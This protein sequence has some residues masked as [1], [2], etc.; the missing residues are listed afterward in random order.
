MLYDREC[1]ICN[2]VEEYGYNE[3]TLIKCKNCNVFFHKICYGVSGNHISTQGI[4]ILCDPCQYDLQTKGKHLNK[5]GPGKDLKCLICFNTGILKRVLV[6]MKFDLFQGSNSIQGTQSRAIWIH[7]ECAIYSKDYISIGNWRNMSN[8][9]VLKPLVYLND[10]SCSF[11]LGNM[12]LL[13][14]CA[15]PACQEFLHAHCLL[16]S[17]SFKRRNFKIEKG[18]FPIICCSKHLCDG[19]QILLDQNKESRKFIIKSLKDEINSFERS[20]DLDGYIIRVFESH[21]ELFAL[22]EFL[23]PNKSLKR[24]TLLGIIVLCD[25]WTLRTTAFLSLFNRPFLIGGRNGLTLTTYQNI[26]N[27]IELSRYIPVNQKYRDTLVSLRDQVSNFFC[28][29]EDIRSKIKDNI[30]HYIKEIRNLVNLEIISEWENKYS[31]YLRIFKVRGKENRLDFEILENILRDLP[32]IKDNVSHWE[33]CR[34]SRLY[35]EISRIKL[36]IQRLSL[37]LKRCLCSRTINIDKLRSLVQIIEC[38]IP[39]NSPLNKRGCKKILKSLVFLE[40]GL[41]MTLER[42]VL[43]KFGDKVSIRFKNE[44]I[45]NNFEEFVNF[46]NSFRNKKTLMDLISEIDDFEFE[47]INHETCN[48]SLLKMEVSKENCNSLKLL[49]GDENISEIPNKY[50]RVLCSRR[51]TSILKR[52]IKLKIWERRVEK[53]FLTVKKIQESCFHRNRRKKPRRDLTLKEIYCMF[54]Q[55]FVQGEMGTRNLQ[56]EFSYLRTEADGDK[57]NFFGSEAFGMYTYISDEIRKVREIE[58][59]YSNRDFEFNFNGIFLLMDFILDFKYPILPEKSSLKLV[60]GKLEKYLAIESFLENSLQIPQMSLRE[61]FILNKYLSLFD[62]YKGN[63]LYKTKFFLDFEILMN[64]VLDK[65]MK[66]FNYFLG[67]FLIIS[68]SDSLSISPLGASSD[69]KEVL[70]ILDYLIRDGKFTRSLNNGFMDYFLNKTSVT[71]NNCNETKKIIR[72]K[73]MILLSNYRDNLIKYISE[74][75]LFREIPISMDLSYS[76]NPIEIPIKWKLK[77]IQR[78]FVVN[79]I[80]RFSNEIEESRDIEE[81]IEEVFKAL[82]FELLVVIWRNLRLLNSREDISRLLAS[83]EIAEENVED[84]IFENDPWYDLVVSFLTNRITENLGL[85]I[86]EGEMSFGPI[87]NYMDDLKYLLEGNTISEKLLLEKIASEIDEVKEIDKSIEEVIQN[88]N[89]KNFEY[90]ERIIKL[91]MNEHFYTL[92]QQG[93]KE[94]NNFF[95]RDMKDTQDFSF[96]VLHQPISYDEEIFDGSLNQDFPLKYSNSIFDPVP[97]NLL[98]QEKS[99]SILRSG[100]YTGFQNSF[101]EGVIKDFEGSSHRNIRTLLQEYLI[102]LQEERNKILFVLARSKKTKFLWF[103]DAKFPLEFGSF[104]DELHKRNKRIGS[105]IDLLNRVVNEM[106]HLEISFLVNLI[107]LHNQDFK[108]SKNDLKEWFDESYLKSITPFNLFRSLVGIGDLV[109]PILVYKL[110]DEVSSRYLERISSWTQ[111]YLEIVEIGRGYQISHD[112]YEILLLY[113]QN[114]HLKRIFQNNFDSVRDPCS[115][116]NVISE[117][118]EE[119]FG[120]RSSRIREEYQILRSFLGDLIGLLKSHINAVFKDIAVNGLYDSKSSSKFLVYLPQDL[121]QILRTRDSRVSGSP[122]SIF[123]DEISVVYFSKNISLL[124]LKVNMTYK[125]EIYYLSPEFLVTLVNEIQFNA[126]IL[127]SFFFS[128]SRRHFE[129]LYALSPVKEH[130]YYYFEGG[131]HKLPDLDMVNTNISNFESRIKSQI[132]S[133]SNSV[134]EKGI[135]SVSLDSFKIHETLEN[136]NSRFIP[137]SDIL[138]LV[139][140]IFYFRIFL[141]NLENPSKR[142]NPQLLDFDLALKVVVMQYSLEKVIPEISFLRDPTRMRNEMF[143]PTEFHTVTQ[144]LASLS[145]FFKTKDSIFLDFNNKPNIH[146]FLFERENMLME[147]FQVWECISNFYF[148]KEN[149]EREDNLSDF[150]LNSIIWVP[151]YENFMTFVDIIEVIF[152]HIREIRFFVLDS[153]NVEKISNLEKRLEMKKNSLQDHGTNSLELIKNFDLYEIENTTVEARSTPFDILEKSIS[154]PKITQRALHE[155]LSKNLF[156]IIPNYKL[157]HQTLNILPFKGFEILLNIFKNSVTVDKQLSRH[158]ILIQNLETENLD[159]KDHEKILSHDIKYLAEILDLR[160]LINVARVS[161]DTL[162]KGYSQFFKGIFRYYLIY[163]TNNRWVSISESQ[164]EEEN[165]G[166]LVFVPIIDYSI[167]KHLYE[168]FLLWNP[169][170]Y[171]EKNPGT[172]RS[173]EF[174][175]LESLI[176]MGCYLIE[177][178]S[179]SDQPNKNEDYL[180][181]QCLLRY[182]YFSE[183]NSMEKLEFSSYMGILDIGKYLTEYM[184]LLDMEFIIKNDLSKKDLEDSH[185]LETCEIGSSNVFSKVDCKLVHHFSRKNK[186]RISLTGIKDPEYGLVSNIHFLKENQQKIRFGWTPGRISYSLKPINSIYFLRNYVKQYLKF[187]FKVFYNRD[188]PEYIKNKDHSIYLGAFGADEQLTIENLFYILTNYLKNMVDYTLKLLV[189]SVKIKSRQNHFLYSNLSKYPRDLERLRKQWIIKN[190]WVSNLNK[191]E[192]IG[193][194]EIKQKLDKKEFKKEINDMGSIQKLNQS[195]RDRDRME[196]K[197]NETDE[198]SEE[199]TLKT[200]KRGISKE[201]NFGLKRKEA[202]KHSTDK[203]RE[204]IGEPKETDSLDTEFNSKKNERLKNHQGNISDLRFTWLGWL[205]FEEEEIKGQRELLDIGLY[206]I[207]NQFIRNDEILDGLNKGLEFRYNGMRHSMEKVEKIYD[208]LVVLVSSNW[209]EWLRS[210]KSKIFNKLFHFQYSREEYEIFEFEMKEDGEKTEDK[211]DSGGIRLLIFPCNLN[212]DNLSRIF[213]RREKSRFPI[214]KN[215]LLGMIVSKKVLDESLEEVSGEQNEGD[216]ASVFG[217]LLPN[218]EQLYKVAHYCHNKSLK[219]SSKM[220]FLISNIGM[221]SSAGTLLSSLLSVNNNSLSGT[222]SQNNGNSNICTLKDLADSI[223]RKISQGS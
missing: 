113:N 30:L 27:W 71:I 188:D 62:T 49:S 183:K 105:R 118:D 172:F 194:K 199:V 45:D 56:V 140:N 191:K 55:K 152:L 84:V 214:S 3:L 81:L 78:Y 123:I 161:S 68:E 186:I 88:M 80:S 206:Q 181:K 207:N 54:F 16:K 98:F 176:Y 204:I 47:N 135:F 89:G 18:R 96:P 134:G 217:S 58:G 91:V 147:D 142:G 40:N 168:E 32:L 166:N 116:E 46:F 23:L 185:A 36:R 7:I 75:D 26:I 25:I 190:K 100:G 90:K 162:L 200:D 10:N 220:E 67:I 198:F 178:I 182:L 95:S 137:I 129:I 5:L 196:S 197:E 211:K 73:K 218:E 180:I 216:E 175:T 203:E 158:L 222:S 144:K 110:I 97:G 9:E 93:E 4:V 28:M 52:R 192:G 193:K 139:S 63:S 189:G 111:K 174:V 74:T 157:I 154:P 155:V 2:D 82:N 145:N 70:S 221:F 131:D 136:K 108:I 167:L 11:C 210:C 120:F 102:L 51:L 115:P 53:T 1:I 128:K 19:S 146:H 12:G 101:K 79:L 170:C 223:R 141:R 208:S 41:I 107:R 99:I 151:E 215:Y 61:V 164:R 138:D 72:T 153:G 14:K 50:K 209:S 114:K 37:E 163:G 35:R 205:S 29:K 48:N 65:F 165:M 83:L 195:K 133:E 124:I 202:R 171:R 177:S 85:K 69:K 122:L 109:T 130:F 6:P 184:H 159:N 150:S 38:E 148:L 33:L 43:G 169:P 117:R 121:I 104:F 94:N 92:I 17:P 34:V 20:G 160:K 127:S 64:R 125:A 8:I 213:N 119:I 143:V 173:S 60:F 59:F 22:P 219:S 13:E 31:E 21:G 15:F 42:S 76:E 112:F 179:F 149:I 126:G 201:S 86:Y 87:D 132:F 39:Q 103:E 57:N 106:M 24:L 212:D 44:E 77:L 187:I 156:Q 66:L